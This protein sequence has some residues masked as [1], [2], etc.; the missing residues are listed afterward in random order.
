MASLQIVVRNEIRSGVVIVKRLPKSETIEDGLIS[1]I[2]RARLLGSDSNF[3]LTL[4]RKAMDYETANLAEHA[5]HNSS[6][7]SVV[8]RAFVWWPLLS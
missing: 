4:T 5:Q 8:E 2:Y 3:Q 7:S 6:T 1:I